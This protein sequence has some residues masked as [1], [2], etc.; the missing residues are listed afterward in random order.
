MSE[1]GPRQDIANGCIDWLELRA[2]V[3]KVRSQAD[4]PPATMPIFGRAF[5]SRAELPRGANSG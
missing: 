4:S 3:R 1:G 5:H 2:P